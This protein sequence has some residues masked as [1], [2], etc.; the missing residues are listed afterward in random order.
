[1]SRTRTQDEYADTMVNTPRATVLSTYP[2]PPS[3]TLRTA[4]RRPPARPRQPESAMQPRKGE[5]DI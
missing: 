2:S 1:M 4:P 3:S 5:A